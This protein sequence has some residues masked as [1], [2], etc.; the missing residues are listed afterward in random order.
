MQDLPF[1]SA[2][3]LASLIRRKKVGCLELLDAYLARVE[4]HNPALNAI[5][6]LDV[7]GARKRAKAADR[8]LARDKP[9]GPLHGV[10]MTIKESFD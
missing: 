6:A 9:W 10:P 5:I 3:E 7:E 2:K 1:R 8:A 4:T